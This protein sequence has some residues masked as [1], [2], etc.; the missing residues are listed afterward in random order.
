MVT[1]NEQIIVDEELDFIIDNCKNANA[2]IIGTYRKYHSQ[3]ISMLTGGKIVLSTSLKQLENFKTEIM[4]I[5]EMNQQ[6]KNNMNEQEMEQFASR[7]HHLRILP[8]IQ[9][10]GQLTKKSITNALG[11][12]SDDT[13]SIRECQLAD[14]GECSQ[15]NINKESSLIIDG[16]GDKYATCKQL[17]NKTE[18]ESDTTDRLYYKT[19][20]RRA[21]LY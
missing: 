7:N 2:Q 17:Q 3:D 10:C 15:I 16:Y 18:N 12:K 21:R 13:L 5:E 1:D 20:V 19:K 11:D 4:N 6:I 9:L 8:Q 14:L